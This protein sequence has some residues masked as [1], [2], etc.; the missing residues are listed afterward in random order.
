[1][2]TGIVFKLKPNESLSEEYLRNT[3]EG[4]GIKADFDSSKSKNKK[5]CITLLKDYL[6]K[7]NLGES[8]KGFIVAKNT[9]AILVPS[10]SFI[11]KLDGEERGVGTI[12]QLLKEKSNLKHFVNN[13]NLVP[14]DLVLRGNIKKLMETDSDLGWP[15]V[16]ADLNLADLFS[17]HEQAPVK[18]ET[19]N[20]I[21]STTQIKVNAND[22]TTDASDNFTKNITLQV[23]V[24]KPDMLSADS[25]ISEAVFILD[26][27]GI[28]DINKVI[29][30]LLAKLPSNIQFQVSAALKEVKKNGTPLTIDEFT[31]QLN[32]A[33]K[34]SSIEI[35]HDL[36][37]A[38]MKHNENCRS[39]FLRLKSLVR[40]S[41]T[42]ADADTLDNVTIREFR[43]KLPVN[44][45]NN[46]NF[47]TAPDSNCVE[48]AQVIMD[49]QNQTFAN[50]LRPRSNFGRNSSRGPHFSGHKSNPSRFGQGKNWKNS[51]N[52]QFPGQGDRKSNWVQK[53]G[54]KWPNAGW[55]PA[56]KETRTCRF[57]GIVGHLERSC[58]KKQNQVRRGA[59]SKFSK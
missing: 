18:M 9:R 42:S 12:R 46:I 8:L 16:A 39:F 55:K 34:K 31:K 26:L 19:S 2:N 6:L 10:S 44:I 54:Q 47:K 3:V 45:K 24:F 58:F 25:W 29:A 50:N 30:V 7:H 14:T 41:L 4:W 35:E 1:M 20:Q 59:H 53:S 15:E 36:A 13:S 49:S 27:S 40:M 57:C 38:R 56:Q 11:K 22:V 28:S 5:F 17:E 21:E 43:A 33:A 48:M 52:R 32:F 51:E 37:N 23:P